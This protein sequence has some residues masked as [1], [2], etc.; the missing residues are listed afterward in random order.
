MRSAE[1]VE[2][3]PLGVT[4]A[5]SR[6]HVR[7]FLAPLDEAVNAGNGMVHYLEIFG[8]ALVAPADSRVHRDMAIVAPATDH[9]KIAHLTQV[10]GDT[11]ERADELTMLDRPRM[12]LGNNLM[13][14]ND[15]FTAKDLE[16]IQERQDTVLAPR[17]GNEHATSGVQAQCELG[18]ME[19]YERSREQTH[20]PLPL[21]GAT[22]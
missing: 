2:N 18:K 3:V 1:G 21:N 12:I 14:D 10:E 20:V 13:V 4:C 9:G 16:S 8:P 11:K 6:A 15:S 19:R 7:V 5:K 22:H 17:E